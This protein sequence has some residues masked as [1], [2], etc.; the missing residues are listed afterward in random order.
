MLK[1]TGKIA[2]PLLLAVAP[3]VAYAQT[4]TQSQEPIVVQRAQVPTGDATNQLSSGTTA[5]SGG[6]AEMPAPPVDGQI[7]IQSEETVL[8]NDLIGKTVYSP[9]TE[10]IG[11]VSDLIVSLDGD[12]EGVVVGV[13]GFLGIGEKDVAIELSE[14]DV[15]P[16]EGGDLHIVLRATREDLE[17]AP[18]F[19]SVADQR[20]TE[21]VEARNNQM[22]HMQPE[23]MSGMPTATD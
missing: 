16:T 13:G 3:T 19:V 12:M 7:L 15:T 9:D 20:A 2:V 4:G 23:P 5:I 17:A 18:G 1:T 10:P 6:A 21:A 22:Q 14:L 11:D 8:A